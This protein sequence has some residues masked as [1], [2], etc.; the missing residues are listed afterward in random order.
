MT[1][2]PSVTCHI[3][4]ILTRRKPLPSSSAD[5]HQVMLVLKNGYYT[6]FQ[7]V[8]RCETFTSRFGMCVAEL[9]HTEVI[10]SFV[11]IAVLTCDVK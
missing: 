2:D 9:M 8:S 7:T 4:Y 10:L 11:T 5:V 1:V 3:G 6:L